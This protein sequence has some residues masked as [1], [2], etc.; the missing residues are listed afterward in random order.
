[1]KIKILALFIFLLSIASGCKKVEVAATEVPVSNADY[2]IFSNVGLGWGCKAAKVYKIENQK[3]YLDES[4]GF[5]KVEAKDY[6]FKGNVLEDTKFKNA[7][8]VL[9]L[10][11]AKLLEDTRETIGCPGCADGGMLY[12]EIKKDNKIQRWR[13]DD[14]VFYKEMD[15]NNQPIPSYLS[16]Y[17]KEVKKVLEIL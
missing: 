7:E 14:A 8:S 9:K 13:I 4:G 5:C 2:I 17:A 15:T 1:M 3:L 11:P 12:L 10:F 16:S 6:V